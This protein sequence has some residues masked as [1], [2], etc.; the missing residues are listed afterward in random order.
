LAAAFVW[1]LSTLEQRA[2]EDRALCREEIQQIRRLVEALK[3]E[4]HQIR[5]RLL[6]K[7]AKILRPDRSR[8]PGQHASV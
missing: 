4:I 7:Q 1:L 6:L 8:G 3:E 5:R 2:H